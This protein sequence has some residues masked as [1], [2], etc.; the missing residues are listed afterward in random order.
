[1]KVS[2]FMETLPKS[3]YKVYNFC[4]MEYIHWLCFY[5]LQTCLF[6]HKYY[7]KCVSFMHTL[8]IKNSFSY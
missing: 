6:T 8:I 3:L 4:Y 2:Y 5:T 7:K 1:M